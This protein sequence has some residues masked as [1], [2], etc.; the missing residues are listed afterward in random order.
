MRAGNRALCVICR[1]CI[2]CAPYVSPVCTLSDLLCACM[3]CIRC[4]C[5]CVCA[6]CTR[7]MYTLCAL[8]QSVMEANETARCRELLGF[9]PAIHTSD[10][11][12]GARL[13]L[14]SK[15]CLIYTTRACAGLAGAECDLHWPIW[16]LFRD[17]LA[18]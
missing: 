7:S 9:L 14:P 18:W 4:V 13:N 6:L 11:I 15:R 16:W 5:A 3:L 2:L 17:A 1:V 10:I 8:S 12:Y